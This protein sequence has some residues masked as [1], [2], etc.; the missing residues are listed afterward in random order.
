MVIGLLSGAVASFVLCGVRSIDHMLFDLSWCPSNNCVGSVSCSIMSLCLV[1]MALYPL[2]QNCAMDNRALFLMSGNK[3][4]RR[5]ASGMCGMSRRA[6]CVASID[7]LLGNLTVTPGAHSL[8]FVQ[9]A[10]I[11]RK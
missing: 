7:M 8:M 5:A 2:S 9:C 1:N 4:Q 6:V 11:P 10:F 3:W